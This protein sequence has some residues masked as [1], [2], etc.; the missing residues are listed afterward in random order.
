MRLPIQEFYSWNPHR[1]HKLLKVW[2]G[3][4]ELDYTSHPNA[5]NQWCSLFPPLES[6]SNTT[7][8]SRACLVTTG[9]VGWALDCPF[10][11]ESKP[12]VKVHFIMFSWNSAK[13]LTLSQTRGKSNLHYAGSFPSLLTAHSVFSQLFATWQAWYPMSTV[14][15]S[16]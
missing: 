11:G 13:S 10:L 2:R 15:V 4:S 12:V 1:S 5:A 9:G 3:L 16:P 7:P 8:T 14:Y 6:Q